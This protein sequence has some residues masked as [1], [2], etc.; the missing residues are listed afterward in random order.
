MILVVSFNARAIAQLAKKMRLEVVVVDFW[1][2]QD[3]FSLVDKVYTVFRPEFKSY[4]AFP[5]HTRNEE[6]LVD[7]ALDV[8]SKEKIDSVLLGSGLDDRP[9]LWEKINSSAPILGNSP[10]CIRAARNLLYIHEIL[11]Q[12]KINFPMTLLAKDPSNVTK[13]KDV[14]GFPFVIKP[15]KTLGGVGIR[16]IRSES[17]LANFLDENSKKLDE[18]YVQEFI[19]GENISTTLVGNK[20]DFKFLSINEQLIGIQKYGTFLPF[21]YCGN[22]TPFEC[23]SELARKIEEISIRI[24]KRFKL[25]GI[26][27]IDFVLKKNTPYFM[28]INPR[29]PGTIELLAM[30][31]QLNAVKLHLDAI[32]GIIPTELEEFQGFAMKVVLFAKKTLKI[33]KIEPHPYLF[34]IPHPNITLEPE[35]PICTIQ[36]SNKNR[37]NLFK[38]MEGLVN[39]MFLKI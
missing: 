32:N 36:I 27:G 33:Q 6:T 19:N 39:Q 22:V 1:G 18:Y 26:F 9:D 10:E 30:I 15:I 21:K 34:D 16:L 25:S 3:L 29:F 31:S 4:A 13:F 37:E 2:D 28:E 12:N 5:D 24:S 8:I 35:D 23:S 11:Q 38:R 20:R 14:T 17:E 7:L